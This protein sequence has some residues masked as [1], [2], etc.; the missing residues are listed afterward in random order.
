MTTQTPDTATDELT[1]AFAPIHKGAMGVAS[2]LVAGVLVAA[3]TAVHVLTRPADPMP[4]ALLSQYFSGYTVTWTGVLVGLFWGAVT[5]FVAGWF[6]A[7]IRNLAVSIAVFGLRTKA[8][9]QQ[10]ADFLDHI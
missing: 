10:T 6:A 3:V 4:L 7:F 9:L 8:A 1:F 2:G 5:G